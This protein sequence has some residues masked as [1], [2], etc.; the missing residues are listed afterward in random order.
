MASMNT[1]MAREPDQSETRKVDKG[2]DGGLHGF[3]GQDGGGQVQH[4]GADLHYCLVAEHRAEVA[5]G[6][7]EAE[8]E[9]RQGQEGEERG[10]GGQPDDADSQ[11]GPHRA[12]DQHGCGAGAGV[13]VR[14]GSDR[15]LEPLEVRPLRSHT[16]EHS[17]EMSVLPYALRGSSWFPRC[18]VDEP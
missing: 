7:D 18:S 16:F 15:F 14:P 10:L 11:R 17:P 6:A 2:F 5:Q 13:A 12:S 3:S 8:E 1:L 4:P 9:G